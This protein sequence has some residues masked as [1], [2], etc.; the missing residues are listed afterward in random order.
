MAQ[1]NATQIQFYM[2]LTIESIQSFNVP[3][4]KFNCLRNRCP[5]HFF[6]H[7][8][9]CYMTPTVDGESSW[10]LPWRSVMALQS[11]EMVI[12][13]VGCITPVENSQFFSLDSLDEITCQK[14]HNRRNCSTS[15]KNQVVQV[16]DCRDHQTHQHQNQMFSS[17][18]MILIPNILGNKG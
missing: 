10:Q 9:S 8:R 15:S 13:A 4:T 7:P 2:I 1:M 16:S 3:L 14:P 6:A 18:W 17:P 11:A 12:V 5:N